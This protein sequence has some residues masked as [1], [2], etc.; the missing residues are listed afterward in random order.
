MVRLEKC[1]F[2]HYPPFWLFPVEIDRNIC[3]KSGITFITIF[4][5]KT[6]TPRL[7]IGNK[8]RTVTRKNMNLAVY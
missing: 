4:S 7:R 3:L 1:T 6:E 2:L 5:E 8:V